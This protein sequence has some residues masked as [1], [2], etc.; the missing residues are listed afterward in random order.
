MEPNRKIEQHEPLSDSD[1]CHKVKEMNK[2]SEKALK[3]LSRL[4]PLNHLNHHHHH[5]QNTN[6][7]YAI[8]SDLPIFGPYRYIGD[9]TYTGQYNTGLRTGWGLQ[10]DAEG[11]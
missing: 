4:G 8:Y 10:I 6:E 3:I 7:T 2:L 9:S 11:S 5:S 1:I